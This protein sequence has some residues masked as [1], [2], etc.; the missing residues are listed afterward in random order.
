MATPICLS[1][2]DEVHVWV[3]GQVSLTKLKCCKEWHV[4][5]KEGRPVCLKQIIKK[6]KNETRIH[7]LC[8]RSHVKTHQQ[9]APPAGSSH[10]TLLDKSI[11]GP[12]AALSGRSRIMIA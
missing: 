6:K 7:P 4:S 1:Q 10:R 11:L 8:G 12:R 2:S 3:R 9:V 5:L